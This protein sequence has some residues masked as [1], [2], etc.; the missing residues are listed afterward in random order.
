VKN[1]QRK[2]VHFVHYARFISLCK[3]NN[4]TPAAIERLLGIKTGNAA[5]WRRGGNPSIDNLIKIA[6]ALNCSVDYLL[7]IS[8][9]IAP[10][11]APP[12][13]LSNQMRLLTQE[14][15]KRTE[16]YID[17]LKS[18]T[19]FAEELSTA[20]DTSVQKLATE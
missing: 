10:S 15:R 18:R 16:E 13:K 7:G 12:D 14:Q 17:F 1:T 3:A 2:G 19:E 5:S 11:D 4:T 9:V 20:L 8:E 6:G